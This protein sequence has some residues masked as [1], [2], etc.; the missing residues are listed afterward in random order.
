[1]RSPFAQENQTFLFYGFLALWLYINLLSAT[2]TGLAHDEAYYWMYSRNLDWGY[3]DHPPATAVLIKIGSWISKNELG[4]RM[5]NVIAITASIIL[6]WSMC[7]K[8]GKDLLLFIILLSGTIIFHVYGFIIVP[9]APL[10]VSAA[11]YFWTLEKFIN[12][13][14]RYIIPLS[15]AVALML[16]SK[17]HSVLIL[18]FTILAYPQLLKKKSFWLV[19]LGSFLL[20][21]PHILWQIHHNYPT[22]QFHLL[23]RFKKPYIISNTTNYIF[24]V[25]LITGPLLSFIYWYAVYKVKLNTVWEKIL[26]YNAVGFVIFFFI[27]SFRGKLSLTGIVWLLFPYLFLVINL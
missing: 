12:N 22:L 18:F 11:F 9:D 1:M 2:F 16:Y 8:Y 3:F 24:G 5:A 13:Q 21:L 23:N 7:K 20:F 10:L 14:S 6:L 15:I 27:S 4:V 25:I 26:K 17:Y 19:A